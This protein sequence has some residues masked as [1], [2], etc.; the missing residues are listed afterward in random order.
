MTQETRN[1][2]P[3]EIATRKAV[4][5]SPDLAYRSATIERDM[6]KS[7]ERTISLTFSSDIELER[8]PGMVEVLSH[9]PD[10]VNLSRLLNGAQLLFNHDP[11]AYIGVVEGATIGAD[12]KGRCVV[13][14]SENEDGEKVWQD[15]QAGILR[16]VSVGYRINEVKL[17]EE[18]ESGVDVYT[19][20]R[21]EPY[22]VS[23]VT[24]PADI[25]V[26]IGRN[27]RS[28]FEKNQPYPTPNKT[29]MNRTTMLTALRARGISVEDSITDDDLSD[30]M[31]R[32][33]AAPA[34][35]PTQIQVGEERSQG[36]NTER[37]R[38]KKIIEAGRSYK[39]PELAQKAI[40][41]GISLDAFRGILLE[42][43][44]K[45]NQSVVEGARP[46]GLSEREATS[47]S[48]M[49]LFRAL[50]ARP[51]D[52][53]RHAASARF[54]LEACKAAGDQI[55]HRSLKGTAIPTDVLLTPLVG[56]RGDTVSI[57]G[58]AG[59][60][61][62]GGSAVPTNL[63]TSSFIEL[64]RN[65]TLIMQLGSELSGLVG[66][67]D[68]PKQIS[69]ATA[70]WLGED[71][72]ATREDVDFGLVQLSPKT[73]ANLGEVTR[74]M[75]TQSSLG[76][77]ALFR[78]DLAKGLANKID[79]A[80]FYGLGTLNQPRG[81]KS[82]SGINSAT[83]A[84]AN[85]P[86]YAEL[87]AMETAIAADNADISK[88]KYVVNSTMKGYLK[89]TQRFA[90]TNGATLW[91]SERP[92]ETVNGREVMVS[93]Q[94]LAGDIFFGNFSD[95]LI[96][97]W[98]GLDITV[99]PYTHSSKGRIR[100]TAFQDVDFAHRRSESFAYFKNA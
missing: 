87:V 45:R 92:V 57:K 27:I 84:A 80:G 83:W 51:E 46:I 35:Q 22:E 59:Y 52:R 56:S 88:T 37:E 70:Y 34:T 28:L 86:T 3:Q 7:D 4:S 38:V 58:G 69:G 5:A 13:R 73:V 19:V 99:D 90:G 60:T 72:D 47:F 9:A 15:V 64:L 41:E 62:T 29:I 97:M 18:R 65:K 17:T 26:G 67:V 49:R 48:F 95:L 25:S 68:I 23:I 21:W 71:E 63:L 30:L 53:E 40:E 54:E 74:K 75:L 36:A 12:G 91:E 96:G 2:F 79:E 61:G 100:Y 8:W 66:N 11:D 94:I 10:A 89:S 82:L 32:S 39:A 42:E 16:N 33:L 76:I 6:L 31:T 44:N 24:I 78:D 14:F 1:Q 50:S 55:T 98:G 77:E 81:L 43:V 20:S 93:N 85:A